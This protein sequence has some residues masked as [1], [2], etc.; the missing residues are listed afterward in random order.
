MRRV[1]D[2]PRILVVDARPTNAELLEVSMIDP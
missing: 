2:Q 1:Q